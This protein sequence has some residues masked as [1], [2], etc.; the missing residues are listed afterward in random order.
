MGLR[1][2]IVDDEP[3]AREGV[4]ML[5]K[6]DPEV[7]AIHECAD[8]QAAVNAIIEMKPDL[9]FL[10]VQMPE[11]DGFEVIEKVGVDRMPNTIFVTAYD[12][13]ALRA[14]EVYALD[15][16]LKPYTNERFF[17]AVQRA[18]AQIKTGHENNL[19]GQLSALLDHLRVGEDHLERLVVKSA[20]RISYVNVEE[21]EWIEAADIYVRLHVG[22]EAHLVRGTMS[23]LEGKL[24]PRKFLRIHRSTI[25]N[26]SHVKEL[27]PLF[28]G[29][30]KVTLKNG[31]QLTSGRSYRDKLQPLL[32][33]PF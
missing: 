16:L 23:G 14:F 13:Y 30:Y 25:V 2:L 15:Y 32:E 26:L 29:E 12:R 10:D 22:H 4:R 6:H 3:L 18:K 21:I 5:L 33:N 7:S 11:M 24:D 28:H 20:G 31:T 19:N 8:G 27:Q 9:V 17:R 1:T